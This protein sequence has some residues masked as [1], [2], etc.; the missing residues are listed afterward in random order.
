MPAYVRD[1]ARCKRVP[2]HVVRWEHGDLIDRIYTY[3]LIYQQPSIIT[4]K[5]HSR[6]QHVLWS[7]QG[8][9]VASVNN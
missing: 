7:N 2:L 3:P 1:L 8:V 9:L 5:K 6:L 4:Y